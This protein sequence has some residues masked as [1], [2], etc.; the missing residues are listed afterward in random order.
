MVTHRAKENAKSTQGSVLGRVLQT[1]GAS[2]HPGWKELYLQCSFSGHTV[3]SLVDRLEWGPRI[4]ILEA[5]GGTLWLKREWWPRIRSSS[6]FQKRVQK[7]RRQFT[8]V[9]SKDWALDQKGMDGIRV[10]M[11]GSLGQQRASLP[12]ILH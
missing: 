7:G 9:L 4:G 5:H 8:G 10:P 12:T 2:G 6:N 1:P 11:M 3:V